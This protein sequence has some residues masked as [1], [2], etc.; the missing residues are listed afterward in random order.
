MGVTLAGDVNARMS[1]LPGNIFERLVNIG[2][3]D[4]GESSTL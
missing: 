2:Q 4:M 1:E 3:A